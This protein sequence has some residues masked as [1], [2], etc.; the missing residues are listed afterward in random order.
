MSIILNGDRSTKNGLFYVGDLVMARSALDAY[1]TPW[2]GIVTHK[3]LLVDAR[4]NQ[5]TQY[6]VSWVESEANE[7][8]WPRWYDEDMILVQ[9][10][11]HC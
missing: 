3:D 10:G 9:P 4:G 5:T 1:G 11:Q 2:V 7:S 6:R 8:L